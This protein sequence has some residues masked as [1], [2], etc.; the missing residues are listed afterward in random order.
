MPI[1]VYNPKSNHVRTFIRDDHGGYI[2]PDGWQLLPV[3]KLPDGWTWEPLPAEARAAAIA[4]IKT[5][6]EADILAAMPAW[7]QRNMIARGLELARKEYRGEKK[8]P[9]ETAEYDAIETAWAWVKAR[10]AQ[11]DLEEQAL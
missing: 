1:A 5:R 8:S 6:C 10:R 4:A 2:P 3:E 11:S 7:K 9:Q